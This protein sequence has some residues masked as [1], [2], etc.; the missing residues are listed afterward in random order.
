MRIHLLTALVLLTFPKAIYA[1]DNPA[2]EPVPQAL[3]GPN[4]GQPDMVPLDEPANNFPLIEYQPFGGPYQSGGGSEEVGPLIAF[5]QQKPEVM[6]KM[7]EDL[8]IF[9]F[10]LKRNLEKSLGEQTP[11]VKMGVAMLL[12]SGGHRIHASYIDGFG[13]LFTLRIGMP[14]VAP[15]TSETKTESPKEPSEWEKARAALYGGDAVAQAQWARAQAGW[16]RDSFRRVEHYDAKVVEALKK[17]VMESLKSA[18][19]LQYV[20]PDEWI[21]VTI[22]GSPNGSDA[23]T[24]PAGADGLSNH[25]AG[26]SGSRAAAGSSRST[27]MTFRVKKSTVDALSAKSSSEEQFAA[28]VE[29]SSYLGAE[30]SRVAGGGGRFSRP[31]GGGQGMFGVSPQLK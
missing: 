29:V 19:N 27:I 1:Q 21:V 15:P 4:G 20:K 24:I 23:Q 31:P 9:G 18:S 8:N 10:I 28:K 16:S 3:V 22:A 26:G 6:D 13:A 7:W 12:E 2:A 25:S 5:S 11:E 17:Q 30:P 14:V